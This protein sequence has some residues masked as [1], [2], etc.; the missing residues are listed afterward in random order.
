MKRFFL[1]GSLLSAALLFGLTLPASPQT[2][3]YANA[4][5]LVGRVQ[6]DLRRATSLLEPARKERARYD[7]ERQRYDNAQRHLSDFDR[8]LSQ[9][10][11]DQGKLDTAINDLKNVVEHN[12]LSSQDR[13]ALTADLR[14][15]RD[16]RS[17]R[18]R[19]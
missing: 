13:D 15:L 17:R 18:G 2:G 12:T 16:L 14:D 19:I 10:K 3:A 5:A 1:R 8:G 9:G 11:F 7:R 4:R 6:D